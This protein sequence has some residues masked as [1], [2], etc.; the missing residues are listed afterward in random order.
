MRIRA[1]ISGLLLLSIILWD[2]FETI[3]LPRHVTRRFRLARLVYRTT[4]ISRSAIARRIRP[5]SRR[6]PFLS[7][8]GPLSLLWHSVFGRSA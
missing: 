4:W 8:Y 5:G 3:I 7:F 6:E 1:V 2:A